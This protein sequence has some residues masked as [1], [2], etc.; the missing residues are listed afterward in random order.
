MVAERINDF[1]S[2]SLLF[3]TIQIMKIETI[4]F[5]VTALLGCTELPMEAYLELQTGDM[6]VLDQDIPSPISVFIGEK[7]AFE[8]S[9][10][11]VETHKAIK[12]TKKIEVLGR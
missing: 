7:E 10:G 4:P 8:G 9:I 3:A 11:L 12:I 2:F 1:L 5:E 6:I